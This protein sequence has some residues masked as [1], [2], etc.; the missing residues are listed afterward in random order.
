MSSRIHFSVA[1]L[2][3]LSKPLAS[4]RLPVVTSDIN[5]NSVF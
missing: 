1:A 2:N 3:Y 4:L 5:V